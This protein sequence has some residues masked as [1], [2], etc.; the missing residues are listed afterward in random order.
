MN[1]NPGMLLS[2]TAAGFALAIAAGSASATEPCG[3]LGECKVLIEINSSDGDIGFHFLMDG[4]DLKSA[5]ILDPKGKTIFMDKAKG[6]L[7]DQALTETFAESAEPVCRK[8]L[9]EDEDDTVVTVKKFIKR[10]SAGNYKFRGKDVEGELVK[11]KSPL[12][13]DLPAAPADVDFDVDTGVISWSDAGDDLGECA[14]SEELD[15]LVADGILPTHPK[16]VVVREYEA[17][18]EPDVEEGDPLGNL[19][20]TIRVPADQLSVSVPAE[21]LAALPAD[22][23]AKLEVGAIGLED[24]ATFTEEDGI[25]V[26]EDAG[27]VFPEE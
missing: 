27:C 7:K 21:L 25:C 9:A 23:P 3:D 18:L 19:K 10:W 8:E 20:F 15:A 1:R 4:D 16:D 5:K 17:V 22:T 6:T 11:G 13:H 26:N 2:A 14:T 24:N 12:T